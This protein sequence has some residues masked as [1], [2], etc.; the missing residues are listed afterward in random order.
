MDR[1]QYFLA[2]LT[3]V[4]TIQ[5]R[6]TP[7]RKGNILLYWFLN[8]KNTHPKI[9]RDCKLCTCTTDIRLYVILITIPIITSLT[10]NS[11]KSVNITVLLLFENKH[12]LKSSCVMLLQ[13]YIRQ[14]V[15]LCHTSSFVNLQ[16]N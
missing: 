12:G 1:Y 15:L 2:F 11:L 5:A 3:W 14:F 16:G 6:S 9:K 4:H 7:L 10:R 8:C 13:L